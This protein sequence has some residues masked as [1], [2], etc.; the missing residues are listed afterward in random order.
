MRECGEIARTFPARTLAAA[1]VEM[2][3]RAGGD[4]LAV[5]SAA[6]D[7]DALAWAAADAAW[8]RVGLEPRAVPP[9]PPVKPT[10]CSAYGP[11]RLCGPRS[12]A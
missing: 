5:R 10:G 7:D 2:Y 4:G 6:D 8:G 9:A 11:R 12:T 1:N 3:V